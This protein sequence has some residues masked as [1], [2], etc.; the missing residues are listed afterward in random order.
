M[1]PG[2]IN[3]QTVQIVPGMNIP[4]LLPEPPKD[5]AIGA[6]PATMPVEIALKTASIREI[7][8]AYDIS[9]EEWEVLRNRPD[10]RKEVEDWVAKLRE[11]GMTFK[12]KARLQSEA[13]LQTAWAMIH[14]KGNTVPATVRADLLKFV[15]KAAGLDE[16]SKAGSN[17]GVQQTA[18]QINIS[19]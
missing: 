18:L 3:P 16:S 7:C 9:R 13:L 5:P 11:E 15:I 19:L 8:E 17:G 12:M 6:Y 2:Q 4:L 14:D 10:F 1:L